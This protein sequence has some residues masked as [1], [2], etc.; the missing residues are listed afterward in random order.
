MG[1]FKT[2]T[3]ENDFSGIIKLKNDLANK[4]LGY[5]VSDELDKLF[6][7]PKKM[8]SDEYVEY[9]NN[10]M[11]KRL[12]GKHEYEEG[13]SL[14]KV[15]ATKDVIIDLHSHK[16]QSQTILVQKGKIILLDS[17]IEIYSNESFFVK[18]NKP[19]IIKY[20]KGTEALIVYLPN[21]EKIN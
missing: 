20:I 7:D 11:I 12:C 3:R 8:D 4:I 2:K 16:N 21:L 15:K 6:F 18:K 13:I 5:N 10:F 1:I 14:F 17:N 19:H 9:S